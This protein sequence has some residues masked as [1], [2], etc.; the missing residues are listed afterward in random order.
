VSATQVGIVFDA[1]TMAIASIIK[2]DHDSALG[3]PRLIGP[4]QRMVRMPRGMYDA[5]H[6][7]AEVAAYVGL[8][9]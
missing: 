8:V 3:D 1:Q 9:G 6:S 5:M 2:P 4:G 7:H